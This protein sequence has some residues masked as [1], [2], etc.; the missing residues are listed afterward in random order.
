MPYS[1]LMNIF[2]VNQLNKS[3]FTLVLAS[4]LLLFGSD[5][6]AQTNS[7]SPL[8]INGLGETSFGITPAYL[9]MGGTGIGY[10]DRYTI[11]VFNPAGYANLEYS[12]LEMSGAHR[13]FRHRIISDSLDQDNYNTYFDYFGFG[14]KFADWIG[15]A[16]SLSPYAAKGYNVSVADS[17]DD[18][19][20]YEYRSIGS[21][22]FDQF[23]FGLALQPLPWFSIGGNARYIFGEMETSNKT[24]LADNRFLS[25]SKTNKTGISD[26]TFDIG[27]QLQGDLDRFHFVAGAVYGFGGS[28][29]ARQISTQYSFINSGILET[30][31]DTLFYNLSEEGSVV[32]PT[33][34][35]FG[36]GL[37]RTV[38]NVPV[39]A[40][41]LVVD[42][43]RVNWQDYRDFTPFGGTPVQSAIAVS[44]RG[45]VGLVMVPSYVI[46]QLR[47]STNYFAISRYR[48]GYSREKGQYYWQEPTTGPTY[49]TQE[50]NLGLTLPI[51]YRSLAPGEQKASF[52]NINIGRGTR[53]SGVESDLKEDY[54][55]L[56]FGITLNDK[57]FQKFRYR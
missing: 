47:R 40:W 1:A 37:S 42:Y 48:F 14:F 17:S 5:A 31:V 51:I 55:N 56:N 27:T 26:L 38:E 36:F 7:V 16:F 44:E 10:A 3:A 12:T 43:R 45:S 28:M 39:N 25:V 20:I 33:S 57:W 11:N 32:L 34:T 4:M 6:S 18:F 23:T 2:K 54:W 29:N 52:L 35:G 19:G 49:V 8:S 9:G 50:F 24:I 46:P 53:W 30:P 13:T 15:G 41:D 21:G 22:G